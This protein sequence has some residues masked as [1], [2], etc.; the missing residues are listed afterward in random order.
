MSRGKIGAF[1]GFVGLVLSYLTLHAWKIDDGINL[2][3]APYIARI[4]AAFNQGEAL[5][6]YT[7]AGI[8][9]TEEISIIVVGFVAVL[10]GVAA[11]ILSLLSVR[12]GEPAAETRISLFLGS[13]PMVL[14]SPLWGLVALFTACMVVMLYKKN[15]TRACKPTFGG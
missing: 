3:L 1:L 11:F 5:P 2:Y 6:G 9:I 4:S 8:S 15:L 12:R 10:L 14:L 13:L 7:S